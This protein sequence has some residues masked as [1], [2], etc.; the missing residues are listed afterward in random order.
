MQTFY[1]KTQSGWLI[2]FSL[3]PV[4][5]F[6]AF[7]LYRQQI[8]GRSLAGET[9]PFW[10]FP[11]LLAF[12][13]ILLALFAT[14]TVTGFQDHLEIKFG[15]GVIRK[16]FYY[17][18]IRSCSVKKNSMIYG[19]GIRAIPGGW[20]YNVAGLW[21]VQLDMK[22]GK[23]YRVGTA[24]PEKLEQFIRSRLSLYGDS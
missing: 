15:I 18:D 7:L 11:V 19:W 1:K 4:L 13:F 22:S 9:A 14:L 3:I 10:I 16:R 21:S 12:F 2:L 20:L 8:W 24:E 6:L 5:V 17:K 23:I